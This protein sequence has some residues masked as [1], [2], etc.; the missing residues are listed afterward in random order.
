MDPG[1]RAVAHP[2]PGAQPFLPGSMPAAG[3]VSDFLLGTVSLGLTAHGSWFRVGQSA[4]AHL[5]PPGALGW[6]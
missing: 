6:R 2:E 3:G 4:P 1:W 5:V